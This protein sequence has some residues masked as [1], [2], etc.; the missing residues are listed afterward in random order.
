[1]CSTCYTFFTLGVTVRNGHVQPHA[2]LGPCVM[3][4]FVPPQPDVTA[5]FMAKHSF[6]S[7]VLLELHREIP[8]YIFHDSDTAYHLCKKQHTMKPENDR[9]YINFFFLKVMSHAFPSFVRFSE[10]LATWS[11]TTGVSAMNALLQSMCALL[12]LISAEYSPSLEIW[13]H[14]Y[15]LLLSSLFCKDSRW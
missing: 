7:Q 14:G 2:F 10:V 13:I 5:A 1:M 6:Q 12:V 8:F 15:S 9:N 11:S 4:I 3:T